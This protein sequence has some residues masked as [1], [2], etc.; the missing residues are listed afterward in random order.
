MGQ[1][2]HPIGFRLG[3]NKDWHAKWFAGKQ[4]TELLHEDL[5]IRRTIAQAY[6]E[7]GIAQVNIE[8]SGA[9]VTVTV[10]TSRTGIIIGRGG[11]RVDEA[12]ARLDRVT[13]KRIRLN[14]QEIRSPETVAYLVARNVVDQLEKRVAFRRAMRQAVSR[15]MARGVKGIKIICSGRLGG[16]E[17]ARREKVMEGQVPLH[18]IKADIDYGLAEAKTTVGRIGVKVWIYK[19]D[20]QPQ[21]FRL[22]GGRGIAEGVSKE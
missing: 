21:P 7:A 19:G 12:R 6:P 3:Y 4:Y 22:E 8:R 14:I 18:T 11:Q 20:V 5:L 2:V 1:K 13:G 16:S 15:T 9:Q 10:H 17:M